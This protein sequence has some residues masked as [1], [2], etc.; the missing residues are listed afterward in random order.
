MYNLTI[1][2]QGSLNTPELPSGQPSTTKK[3][4]KH[5]EDSCTHNLVHF[6]KFL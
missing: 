2:L 5:L 6:Q 3:P 1:F 4:V